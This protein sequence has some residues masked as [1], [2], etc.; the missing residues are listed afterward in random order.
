MSG[1]MAEQS[2][3]LAYND[4]ASRTLTIQVSHVRGVHV[5]SGSDSVRTD[6]DSH[7]RLRCARVVAARSRASSAAFFTMTAVVAIWMAAFTFMYSTRDAATA[8]RWARLAYLGVPFIAPAVYWFTVEILRIERRRRLAHVFAWSGAAFFSAIAVL[9][10]HLIPRVQL[11][12]LGFYPRYAP[13]VGARVSAVLLRLSR[14]RAGRVPPRLSARARH[15]ALRIRLLLIAF[16]IA[17]LGCVD[18]LPKYG[19]AAYPFGYLADPRIRDRGRPR[20]PHA[21]TSCRS[22]RRWPRRR[23]SARWPTCCSSAIARAAS[24]SPTAPR[25]RLLGY[26]RDRAGRQEHQRSPGARRRSLG[27]TATPLAAQRRARLRHAPPASASSSRCPSRRSFTTAR[28][29]AR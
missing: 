13:I 6:G 16:G 10:E 18:Y 19:I 12:W 1:C 11:Y 9:T 14:R 2:T 20:H 17:Y 5:H 21:T 23:S 26:P 15:R 8:L 24:S 28:P 29:P 22:R 25:P 7:P 27:E 4:A 3:F